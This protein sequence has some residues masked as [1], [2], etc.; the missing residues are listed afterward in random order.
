MG[1]QV[2]AGNLIKWQAD[3]LAEVSVARLR[4]GPL[5]RSA[6]STQPTTTAI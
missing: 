2:G 4:G 6:L 5:N 1:V 3:M